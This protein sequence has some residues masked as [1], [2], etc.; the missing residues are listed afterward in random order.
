[1]NNITVDSNN[2]KD[3]NDICVRLEC[4]SFLETLPLE[5]AQ[6]IRRNCLDFYITSLREMLKHLPYKDIIFEQLMFLKPN[7]ALY[8]E[9]RTKIKDLTLLATRVGHINL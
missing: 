8:Y 6:E 5:H 3:V 1:M 9:G 7:I 2:Q 4:E